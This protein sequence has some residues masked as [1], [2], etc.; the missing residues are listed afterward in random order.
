ML[1]A[2]HSPGAASSDLVGRRQ[3][4]LDRIQQ[5]IAASEERAARAWRRYFTLQC[6]TVGLAALTPCFIILAKE[7]PNSWLFNWLQ[8]FFPATAAIAAGVSHLF[9]WREDAVRYT[10]LAETIRSQLWRFQTRSGEFVGLN[11]DQSLDRLV[12]RVDELNLQS[13]A[14]WSSAQLAEAPTPA[15]PASPPEA[16]RT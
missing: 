1:D 11:D 10:T 15:R 5:L 16:A 7:S 14:R 8:L 13:V 2:P 6:L 3:I 12:V 9:H 4:A